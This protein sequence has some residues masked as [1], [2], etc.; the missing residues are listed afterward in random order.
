MNY[1]MRI[2]TNLDAALQQLDVNLG[3]EDR[4]Y[5]VICQESDVARF[6]HNLGQTLR[7]HWKLWHDSVLAKW[8]GTIGIYHADDMSGIILVSYWRAVNGVPIEL[9]EQVKYYQAYWAEQKAR[10]LS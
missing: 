5:F 8:F 4:R 9:G 1:F 2:P 10:E 7:N 3:I 6:H